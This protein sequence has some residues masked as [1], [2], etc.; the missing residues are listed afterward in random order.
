[1]PLALGVVM[2]KNKRNNKVYIESCDDVHT[3]W[4]RIL[5]ELNQGRFGNEML[6][7]DFKASRGEDFEFEILGEIQ[8]DGSKQDLNTG[9]QLLEAKF[10]DEYTPFD[11]LGYNIKKTN[12]INLGLFGNLKLD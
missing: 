9:I 7:A 4:K 11:E 1:M 12:K 3:A 8:I 6:Q 5:H 10:L 2:V